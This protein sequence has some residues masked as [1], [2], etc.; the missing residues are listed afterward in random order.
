MAQK[1]RKPWVVVNPSNPT[2]VQ[3]LLAASLYPYTSGDDIVLDRKA[4]L[5]TVKDRIEADLASA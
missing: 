3:R 4:F 2:P 1:M 5:R